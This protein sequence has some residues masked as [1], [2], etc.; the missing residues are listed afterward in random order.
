MLRSFFISSR[1]Q[2]MS[3]IVFKRENLQFPD[4]LLVLLINGS[5][6]RLAGPDH[7]SPPHGLLANR[8][9]FRNYSWNLFVTFV[10]QLYRSLFG[11]SKSTILNETYEVHCFS[12]RRF[13]RPRNI[14]IFSSIQ[15]FQIA[16]D[17]F[18]A[19]GKLFLPW[20]ISQALI[21][22]WSSMNLSLYWFLPSSI[23]SPCML[24]FFLYY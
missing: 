9:H 4:S 5:V 6:R 20:K 13:S 12:L 15:W 23:I 18:A 24:H 22:T 1:Y 3:E 19:A 17:I 14:A 8:I 11:V 10:I 7:L 2:Q 21:F 16:F